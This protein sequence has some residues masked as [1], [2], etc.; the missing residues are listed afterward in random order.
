MMYICTNSKLMDLL[1]VNLVYHIEGNIKF[2]EM[3]EV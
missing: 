2:G 3:A 1:E